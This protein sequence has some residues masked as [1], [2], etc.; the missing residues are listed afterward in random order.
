[1]LKRILWVGGLAAAIVI[2]TASQSSA[3]TI[4]LSAAFNGSD[5]NGVFGNPSGGG[6]QPVCDVG[7]ALLTGDTTVSPWIIKFNSDQT[8][9]E[10]NSGFPSITGEE[11]SFIDLGSSIQWTYNPTG[12]DPDVRYWVAK[13]A[14]AFTL[15]WFVDGGP[16]T[17]T[18]AACTA[19]SQNPGATS[20]A[21]YNFGCLSLAL[22]VTTGTIPEAQLSHF[23][24][25]DTSNERLTQ[26][27]EPGT[28]V[29]IGGGIA[30][31]AARLRRRRA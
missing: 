8:A 30:L 5:C 15:F 18:P 6:G 23:T 27:P 12:N 31:L 3:G 1:M 29:M 28:L 13:A 2:G 21:A 26:T 17:V 22:V 24:F 25:Y 11:F 14:N 16:A 4:L 19:G 7:T 20:S 10:T 9:D